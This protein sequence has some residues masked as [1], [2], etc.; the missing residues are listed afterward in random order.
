M[1]EEELVE[2]DTEFER[3]SDILGESEVD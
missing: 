1:D 3:D 2:G